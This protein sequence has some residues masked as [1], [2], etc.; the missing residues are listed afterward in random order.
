MKIKYN[1]FTNKFIVFI[2]LILL[3]S[4]NAA[5]AGPCISNNWQPTFVHDNDNEDGPWYVM[6]NGK[7]IKMRIVNNRSWTEHACDLIKRY[8]VRDRTGYQGCLNYTRIQCGCKRGLSETNRICSNF[9]AFHK[10]KQP[11]LPYKTNQINSN[12]NN[13]SLLGEIATTSPDIFSSTPNTWNSGSNNQQT[14]QHQSGGSGHV[15]SNQNQNISS[16][17]KNSGPQC[18]DRNPDPSKYRHRFDTNNNP[19][20]QTYIDCNYYKDGTLQA[21]QPYLNNKLN[22]V[23]IIHTKNNNC[24]GRYVSDRRIYRN[25]KIVFQWNYLCDRKTGN[26]YKS[27]MDA[28]SNGIKTNATSWHSNGVKSK[29][30]DYKPNGKIATGYNYNRQGKLTYCTKYDNKGTPHNF[31]GNYGQCN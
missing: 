19:N 4:L 29:Y 1:K 15:N 16:A 13:I 20:D 6:P 25:G 8:G 5:Y 22:G 11:V 9:L 3:T 14:N 21:Q 17:N 23:R 10:R 18:K 26:I 27:H 2:T 24:G 28:Y 7:F 30:T 12:Q 31:N